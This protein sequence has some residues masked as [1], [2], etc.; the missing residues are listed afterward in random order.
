MKQ[1]VFCLVVC[2][3]LGIGSSA[4]AQEHRPALD[5]PYFGVELALGF[6]GKVDLAAGS[7]RL[8][9]TTITANGNNDTKYDADVA[10]GGAVRYM[11]PLHRY[12]ALGARI[13][14]Q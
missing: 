1:S 10:I 5:D 3:A 9:N 11:R 4:S 13:A 14:V 6:A 12:F 8:G 7:V 2:S